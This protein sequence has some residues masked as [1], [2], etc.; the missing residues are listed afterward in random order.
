[1][2]LLLLEFPIQ[3]NLIIVSYANLYA[4]YMLVDKWMTAYRNGFM[5]F[6]NSLT[7]TGWEPTEA[8]R[9]YDVLGDLLEHC[10]FN[11]HNIWKNLQFW[12]SRAEAS[13]FVSLVFSI[14]LFYVYIADDRCQEEN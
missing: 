10:F 7:V 12:E 1:M 3:I 9:L 6:A 11:L 13:V 14:N 2:L 5:E 8:S 4:L